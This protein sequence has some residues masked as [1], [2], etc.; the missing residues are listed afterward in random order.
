M[1][2][3]VPHPHSLLLPNLRVSI[4]SIGRIGIGKSSLLRA[5]AGLWPISSGVLHRPSMIG[6]NGVLFLSQ[7]NY[8]TKGTLREQMVYPHTVAVSRDD[9]DQRFIDLLKSVGLLYLKSRWYD[10]SCLRRFHSLSHE[11]VLYNRGLDTEA[12]WADLLSSGEQQRLAFARLLYHRPAYAIMDEATSAL[13]N[14][15]EALVMACVARANITMIS[16]AHRPSLAAYHTQHLKVASD[17]TW[18]ITPIT[19]DEQRAVAFQ[20]TDDDIKSLTSQYDDTSLLAASASLAPTASV[21]HHNELQGFNMVFWKRLRSL[22]AH[23]FIW[24][25]VWIIV[26]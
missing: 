3:Q 24:K 25:R 5:I 23:G 19:R 11:C 2:H 20:L 17:M 8:I 12:N 15:M 6:N 26:M 10:A 1:D 16:V 7:R 22:M 18:S 4:H 9:G 21:N 14:D 13:D